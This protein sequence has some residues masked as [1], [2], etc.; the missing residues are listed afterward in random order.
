MAP[1]V[2]YSG[3][4]FLFHHYPCIIPI[5][6]LVYCSRC[7]VCQQRFFGC[8]LEKRA[9]NSGLL[10]WPDGKENGSHYSILGYI[11]GF[12]RDNN[13]KEN[14]SYYSILGYTHRFHFIFYFVL[15]LI[16]HYWGSNIPRDL[17]QGPRVSMSFS[18]L[19][20]I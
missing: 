1:L 4:H 9:G 5:D 18:I 10:L 11:L 19:C 7:H 2:Y 8:E 14:G 13:G 12:Y 15:H 20:S 17:S 16:L 6:T 3:Y